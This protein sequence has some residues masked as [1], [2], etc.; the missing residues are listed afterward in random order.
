MAVGA[1]S[2]ALMGRSARE[3]NKEFYTITFFIALIAA[4]SYLAMA[5]GQGVTEVDG[6]TVYWARYVDWLFTTPLLLLDLALL[7]RAGRNLVFGLVGADVFMI[8]TGLIASLSP[9]PLNYLWWAV[10]T[11]AFVALLWGLLGRLSAVASDQPGEVGSL[12]GTLRNLTA[13]LWTAYPIVWMIG[14][15]GLGLVGLGVE[16][17]LFMILDLS[18]KVGFGFLLLTNRA[19][20]ERVE[21]GRPARTEPATG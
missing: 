8:A 10:S 9:A 3:G 2:F 20:L 15:E 21:V 6:R 19:V 14:T 16:V 4:A 7:V 12:F 11:A 13:V 5:L 18:A 1:L 17:L